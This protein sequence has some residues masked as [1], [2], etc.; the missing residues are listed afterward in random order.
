MPVINKSDKERDVFLPNKTKSA[1]GVNP[2][3]RNSVGV[4]IQDPATGGGA[5]Y[6]RVDNEDLIYNT[7]AAE[8]PDVAAGNAAAAWQIQLDAAYSAGDYLVS[9]DPA[10]PFITI[11]RLNGNPLWVEDHTSTDATQKIVETS[12]VHFEC[13]MLHEAQTQGTGRPNRFDDGFAF[14]ADIPTSDRQTVLTIH[15]M[16]TNV[17]GAPLSARWRL[18]WWFDLIGWA[19]DQEVGIRT[20]TQTAGFGVESDTIQVSATGATKVAV[21]LVEGDAGAGPINLPG[22]SWFSTIG[23]V[24]N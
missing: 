11:T 15:N 23:L 4:E 12:G 8:Q 3:S 13:A 21:E 22:D 2:S 17:S 14:A 7:I 18:W 10:T 6:I 9:N 1:N 24:S 16:L 5:F 19:E 20:V